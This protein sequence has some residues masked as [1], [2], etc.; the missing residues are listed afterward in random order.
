[1]QE[2]APLVDRRA[3]GIVNTALTAAIEARGWRAVRVEGALDALRA[4]LL[5]GQPVIVL[6]PERGNRYHYVVVTGASGDEVVVH[7]P[8][9]GPSRAMR[10][11]DFEQAWRQ[12]GFWPLVI[13]PPAAGVVPT[14]DSPAAANVDARVVPANA[15]DAKLAQAVAD[16]RARGFEHAGELLGRVHEEC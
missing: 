10:A 4:R 12:A 6:V 8:S 9:W 3:G 5:D 16:V 7:D 2:F 15:C 1:V 11:A 14:P 13:L